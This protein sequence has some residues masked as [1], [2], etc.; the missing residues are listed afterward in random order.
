MSDAWASDQQR[1]YPVYAEEGRFTP[2]SLD[3]V[4]ALLAAYPPIPPGVWRRWVPIGLVVLALGIGLMSPPALAWLTPWPALIAAF[5]YVRW[6][7][8]AQQQR[9]S[10]AQRLRD[11]LLLRRYRDAMR[12]A[13]RTLPRMTAAPTLW[14]QGVGALGE[15][16]DGVGEY[17]AAEACYEAL[18]DVLPADHPLRRRL[19]ASRATLA[20]RDDRL[21]DADDALR[22]ARSVATDTS[23]IADAELAVATLYQRVH[24]HHV[25][26]GGQLADESRP[27]LWALGVAGA[28]GHAMAALCYRRVGRTDDAATAW[29]D[30][31][32][33]LPERVIVHRYPELA[34]LLDAEPADAGEAATP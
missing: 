15:A 10:S 16:L 28:Y 33:L 24:T 21:A 27:K 19:A 20:L 3:A 25:A 7:A 14:A 2:P 11:L 22:R 26:D 5:L 31:R 30:A 12:L 13:W 9:T 23:P 4:Q 8:G 17:P 6:Q 18:T 34:E 1:V 29:D 32:A